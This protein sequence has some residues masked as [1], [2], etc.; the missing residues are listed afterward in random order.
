M[1][2][3]DDVSNC[4]LGE[5]CSA[6]GD[7][8]FAEDLFVATVSTMV[9][10]YCT[11]LCPLCTWRATTV[12]GSVPVAVAAQRSLEHCGHLGITVDE[13]AAAMEQEET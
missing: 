5:E 4:P 10:V 11:T 12:L 7:R 6:C 3:L 1:T 8:Q 2:D 9:G 13:M